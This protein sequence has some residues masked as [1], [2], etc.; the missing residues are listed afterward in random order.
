MEV[1]M[2]R[3]STPVLLLGLTVAAGCARDTPTASTELLAPEAAAAPARSAARCENVRGAI[4]GDFTAPEGFT[5]QGL[6]SAVVTV[7]E[8]DI[9]GRKGQGT[10]HS[11]TLHQISTPRGT[12]MTTDEGVLAPI[13]PPLYRLNHRWT[14]T[15][16]TGDLDGASGF[17]HPHALINLGTGD[18]EGFY[19]GRICA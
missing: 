5:M 15:G 16:A 18:I 19:H 12:I 4:E 3:L 1:S 2:R 9:K 7:L 8:L 10:I 14:I 11:V 17:L 13:D 6:G